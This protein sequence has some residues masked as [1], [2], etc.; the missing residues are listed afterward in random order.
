MNQLTNSPR[1]LIF[2]MDGTLIASTHADYT[3][4]K[5]LFE[6]YGKQFSYE[7]YI[8]AI[9][10]KSNDLAKRILNIEGEALKMALQK[11]LLY[12]DEVVA[13]D[14]LHAI[15][16]AVELL[17]HLKQ[18]NLKLALATSSRRV[19]MEKV[20]QQLGLL[21]FFEVIVTGEEV[22]HGKP[23]PDIFLLAAKKLDVDPADCI[24]FEDAVR[25]VE[26]AKNA[27]MYCIAITNTH[28]ADKLTGADLIIDSFEELLEP[29]FVWSN[30]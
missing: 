23:A 4:W 19:K 8:P 20:M 15:P 1:A 28:V 25:G 18:Q 13:K 16:F 9:G 2:D 12:F 29:G 22:V 7:E 24:V 21:H 26:A 27:G 6:D 17:S 3:A 11:K 30:Q 10:I 5:R 14:G